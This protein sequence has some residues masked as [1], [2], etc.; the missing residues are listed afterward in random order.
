VAY[1]VS[2]H[3]TFYMKVIIIAFLCMSLSSNAQVDISKPLPHATPALLTAPVETLKTGDIIIEKNTKWRMTK[4]KYLTGGLLFLAGAAKGFNETL[5]YNWKGFNSVF[6]K[7][8]PQWFWPQQSFK[9]KYKDGD[10]SKGA[11]FPLSTSV[12][13]MFTDQYHLN[14]FIQRASMTTALIIKIGEGKKPFKHYLF[15]ALYY[16]A[17]YQFGFGSVYYYFKSRN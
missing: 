11:K 7:A 16:T 1:H 13:V 8:N 12:L 3:K 2:N 14:N 4:N 5:L 10:Q 17:S 9:N 15:D 6:P